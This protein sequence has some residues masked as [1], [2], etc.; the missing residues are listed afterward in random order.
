MTIPPSSLLFDVRRELSDIPD[1]HADD[2]IIEQ[3]TV[4]A[5]DFCGTIIDVA[6]EDDSYIEHCVVTLAAYFVYLNYTS[7]T[8]RR[9]GTIPQTAVIRLTELRRK[10]YTFISK[11]AT[12]PIDEYFNVDDSED[13]NVRPTSLGLV[14]TVSHG[15]Y[16]T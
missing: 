11:V 2:T 4:Q 7:L 16:T 10:A 15:I 9:L 6:S 14:N 3:M 12:E 1:D 8:E 5:N 13:V